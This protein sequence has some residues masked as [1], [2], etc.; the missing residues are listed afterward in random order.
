LYIEKEGFEPLLRTSRIGQKF[1]LSIMSCKGMSVTAA[2]QLVDQTCAR[3]KVSLFILRDFDIKGFSIAKTLHKSNRRYQ[4]DT[5]S[6]E[7]LKVVSLA[8]MMSPLPGAKTT[9]S[10]C[11]LG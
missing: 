4:F 9:N 3:Y 7:D 2:R 6:G 1:D 8:W 5:V 10:R 11:A